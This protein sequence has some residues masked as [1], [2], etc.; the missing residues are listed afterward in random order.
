MITTA[1][2]PVQSRGA[3][4]SL[5]QHQ[6]RCFSSSY[7][8]WRWGAPASSGVTGGP[9]VGEVSKM[10][11]K[12]PELSGVSSVEGLACGGEH[13]AVVSNGQ[14]YTFGSNKYG[15]LARE[16]ASGTKGDVDDVAAVAEVE[17]LTES[18]ASKL[19]A[20]VSCGAFH[21]MIRTKDGAVH[22]AG[23]GGS[24][25]SGQGALGL[26]D[27]N[28]R[29]RFDAVQRLLELG[30]RVEEVSCGTQHAMMR[31]KSDHIYTCGKGEF[32]ILGLGDSSDQAEPQMLEYF[33]DMLGDA[34]IKKVSCGS[35]FSLILDTQGRLF[36]FGRND[37]GQLGLGEESMGDMY[38]AER[39]PREIPCLKLEGTKI[40]DAVC[41]EHHIVAV[42]STGAV[43]E[44]G[45]RGIKKLAAGAKV[46]PVMFR[47]FC[48]PNLM[49]GVWLHY[50][51]L[52]T[53]SG[54]VYSWG[55]K[56]SGCL[57]RND[58]KTMVVPTLVPPK[59]FGNHRVVDI[60]GGKQRCLAVT[61]DDEYIALSEEEAEQIRET[62]VEPSGKSCQVVEYSKAEDERSQ[63]A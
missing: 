59:V 33:Q 58:G 60:E 15:Q 56:S 2:L 24:W 28:N 63:A 47:Q 5:M 17:A 11:T 1:T 4:T 42:A 27:K 3:L 55:K 40:D 52:L 39:Y 16:S 41:G 32:G 38:S 21:T 6:L 51:F 13:S 37:Y 45:I 46:P 19:V 44:N 20:D 48:R 26:G 7:T 50:S 57:G 31:T 18:Q 43:Y 25:F 54:L 23:W 30:E 12:I 49:L 9:T 22:S 14:V 8:V 36:V 61:S 62:I 53:E 29:D 10:P 34:H 35:N